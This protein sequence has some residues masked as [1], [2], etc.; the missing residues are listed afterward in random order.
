MEVK[1]IDFSLWADLMSALWFLTGTSVLTIGVWR[2][3]R[4]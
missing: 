4:V 2:T 1:M 3:C